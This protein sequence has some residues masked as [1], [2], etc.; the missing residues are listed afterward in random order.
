MFIISEEFTFVGVKVNVV[1]P[2]LG[3]GTRCK[4]ITALDPYLDI[5]ILECYEWQGFSVIFTKEE[6]DDIMV[7]TVVGFLAISSHSIRSLGCVVTQ[8]RVVHTLNKE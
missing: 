6:R 2:N 4:S 8:Q 3:S 7:T 5:M 1:T